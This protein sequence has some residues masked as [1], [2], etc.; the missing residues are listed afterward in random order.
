[1]A[2]MK[3]R[4]ISEKPITRTR[5]QSALTNSSAKIQK[6]SGPIKKLRKPDATLLRAKLIL[7]AR[8]AVNPTI[9]SQIQH[10][11]PDA[12]SK[13]WIADS[14]GTPSLKADAKAS[15]ALFKKRF[16]V[17]DGETWE[18]KQYGKE[19][20]AALV[21]QKNGTKNPSIDAGNNV[22]IFSTLYLHHSHPSTFDRVL[23]V[24]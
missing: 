22:W 23:M 20:E 10:E 15:T 4:N 2:A 14:T 12:P 1:M 24:L 9:V 7:A 3:T 18:L 6:P 21:A 19:W 16:Y 5:K 11:R 17:L 8:T 13:P